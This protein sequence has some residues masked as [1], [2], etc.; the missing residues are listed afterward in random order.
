MP[1]SSY[2]SPP[3]S[4]LFPPS[5]PASASWGLATKLAHLGRDSARY[6]GFVNMPIYRGST[7]LFPDLATLDGRKPAPLR[8][9]LH[10]SPQHEA[11][12]QTLC[13]LEGGTGCV[14]VSS[15]L[16]AVTV[17]MLA[18]LRQGDRILIT[19]GAYEPTLDFAENFLSKLGIK[20]Q[21]Y[22][23]TDNAGLQKILETNSDC[24][25]I[26]I[27]SP[28]SHTFELTDIP[29]LV[30]IAKKH[31]VVTIAD[32]TWGAG[33]AIRPLDMGVDVVVQSGTKY[34]CGHSDAMLGFCVA[35]EEVLVQQLAQARAFLGIY[36]A[37]DEIALCLR[38][39]RSLPVRYEA[40]RLAALRICDFLQEQP[41]VSEILHP[42]LASHP[43]HAL[44]QRD[45]AGS[46]G[47]FSFLM[48]K[49]DNGKGDQARDLLA[50]FTD[51][52]QFFG[53]GYS[54]GGYESLILPAEV[55]GLG[56]KLLPDIPNDQWLLRVHVGL[57]DTAD[58]VR[59][60]DD[61]F[62]R[63]RAAV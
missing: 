35:K 18:L 38:G 41:E 60:L 33:I 13:E 55:R 12:K 31:D 40:H 32:N 30:A 42:A 27:E 19:D 44:W 15:G 10:S 52:L 57:E 62:R 24:K 61:A 53:M 58:L 34:V 37:P 1:S 50:H 47:L 56:R 16:E 8:Y 25:A 21:R 51:E 54:W 7:I 46:C 28:S 9:G 5:S 26:L 43:Q 22:D 48:K 39:M 59:D 2:Y 11:L 49:K 20:A 23:P 36:N 45:C 29:A 6:A 17:P 3:S 63:Y 4:T 14:L